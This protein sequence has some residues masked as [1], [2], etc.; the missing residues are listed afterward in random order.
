M[1]E[2]EMGW[3]KS[4]DF[5]EKKVLKAVKISQKYGY[6]EYNREFWMR[7]PCGVISLLI[8]LDRKKSK[9]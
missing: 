9:I 2:R 3:S 7:Q 6:P 8:K 5:W 1:D 4:D